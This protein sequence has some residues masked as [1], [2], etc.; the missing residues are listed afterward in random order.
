MSIVK[1]A[2][3]AHRANT[4]EDRFNTDKIYYVGGEHIESGELFVHGKGVIK[5]STIGPMFYCGFTAGQILFVTRNPHL[6]KCGIVDFDGICSE[7]T[8][9]IETK[10]RGVL[11]Q[12]YLALIMQ[13]NDFW[14]YCEE[15]KSGGVNYFL[16][17]S[18][19][20]DYEFDL[21]P[22][23]E[24]KVLAEKLW[25]A[26]R[27]KESYK[28][29]LA[30]TEEMVKSQFI[31]M[32]GTI[33]SPRGKMSS[34]GELCHIQRGG[35]PRPIKDYITTDSNGLNWI[36]IGDTDDSMYIK[37][38]EE[39]IKPSGLKKTRQVYAGDLLL[40]N[41]MS[42]GRPYILK[43]DGCIHDGW[44]V[45]HIKDE[46]I[47]TQI[48]LCAYLSQQSTYLVMSKLAAG[49]VVQNLN[50]E[51]VK[52]L[53]VILPPMQKQMEYI[54]ILEQADKSEFELRKSIDA[55]DAVIKSLIN[56]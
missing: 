30:A 15:N 19:L 27:L 11:L 12:E 4:K 53:P 54:S 52:K 14:D 18:T 35:S 7:K 45:L 44:L 5:G 2:D 38:T 10:D 3:V 40:S 28:K 1:F 34:L 31:E 50:S 36:K 56:S 24:Q 33:N 25:A 17:W 39:K 55:I 47:L 46:S 49:G 29:L 8:L 41:S 16:N 20:A 21:P 23:A 26:Y 9:V 51:I 6:K 32:F 43:I 48:Y 22:L 37:K 42:F 13:S